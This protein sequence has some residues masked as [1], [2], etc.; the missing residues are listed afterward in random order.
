[1]A[2]ISKNNA[3]NPDRNEDC[4]KAVFSK[5]LKS[6]PSSTWG[7]LEDAVNTIEGYHNDVTGV[8]NVTPGMV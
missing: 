7:K 6:D 3:F 5:W 1:L 8:C 4:C 2:L